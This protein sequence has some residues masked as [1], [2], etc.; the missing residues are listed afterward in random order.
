M[1]APTAAGLRLASVVRDAFAGLLDV[2]HIAADSPSEFILGG[3]DSVLQGWVIPR[4]AAVLDRVPRTSLRLIA[5][6]SEDVAG[7]LA[8]AQIDLGLLRGAAPHGLRSRRLGTIR[9]ALFVPRGLRPPRSSLEQVLAKVPLALQTSEPQVNRCLLALAGK[10]LPLVRLQ[11]ETF[12][13]ALRAVRSGS[14]ASVLPTIARGDLAGGGFDE[15]A[16]PA[17]PDLT[18]KLTLAWR[19]QTERTRPFAAPLIEALVRHLSL[20]KQDA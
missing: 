11:C 3:G 13:Q 10:E 20:G 12:V 6:S 14:Y 16:L 4:L 7:R 5:L 17:S 2:A 1:L 9:Y 8:D 15:I 18:I 19:A